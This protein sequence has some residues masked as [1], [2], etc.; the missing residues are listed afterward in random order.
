MYRCICPEVNRITY[1]TTVVSIPD[2]E[3]RAATALDLDVQE[4]AGTN[5]EPAARGKECWG[6]EVV[7]GLR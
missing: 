5:R 6:R 4:L 2:A 1:V 3:G 7:G